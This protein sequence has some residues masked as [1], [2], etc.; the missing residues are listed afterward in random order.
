LIRA[1][2]KTYLNPIYEEYGELI[3]DYVT[4]EGSDYTF[5]SSREFT[6]AVNEL[7]EHTSERNKVA[8]TYATSSD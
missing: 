6:S 2:N 5:T 7:E 4:A 8:T 1:F 3:K